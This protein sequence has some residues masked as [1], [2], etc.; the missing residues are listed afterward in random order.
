MEALLERKPSPKIFYTKICC[1]KHIE[2]LG[3]IHE[4]EITYSSQVSRILPKAKHRPRQ[5]YPIL[6]KRFLHQLHKLTTYAAHTWGYTLTA[7]FNSQIPQ[8]A[9]MYYHK[10]RKDKADRDFKRK[11][12]GMETDESHFRRLT[13]KYMSSFVIAHPEGN[14]AVPVTANK[15]DSLSNE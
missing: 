5:L 12:T 2:Y 10:L 1:T 15:T 8:T 7:A 13:S 14:Q 3:A 9:V 4:S 11:V 6:Y